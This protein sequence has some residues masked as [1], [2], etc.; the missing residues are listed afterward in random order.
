MSDVVGGASLRCRGTCCSGMST[1]RP[2][3]PRQTA[4]RSS[5]VMFEWSSNRGAT[6]ADVA[7]S[8]RSFGSI[9]RMGTTRPSV[10][11]NQ[12]NRALAVSLQSVRTGLEAER[13]A[14]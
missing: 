8:L 4:L 6:A 10:S 7:A 13:R 12:Q 5:V 14:R 3:T 2:S 11:M 1:D 9:S